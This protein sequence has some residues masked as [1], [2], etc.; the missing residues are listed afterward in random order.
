MHILSNTIAT[1][2]G[3]VVRKREPHLAE[4]L[5]RLEIPGAA[6]A[7]PHQPQQAQA[8]PDAKNHN[9]PPHPPH[10]ENIISTSVSEAQYKIPTDEKH[11]RK[12]SFIA[13]SAPHCLLRILTKMLL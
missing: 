7:A 6:G 9:R 8:D 5:Y 1:R 4:S 2:K 11:Y 10:N 12:C 3:K 13:Y